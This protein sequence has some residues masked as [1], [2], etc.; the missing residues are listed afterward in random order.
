MTNINTGDPEN[1]YLGHVVPVVEIE[2]D[3]DEAEEI[4]VMAYGLNQETYFEDDEPVGGFYIHTTVKTKKHEYTFSYTFTV[5]QL[6]EI[7]YDQALEAQG[8]STIGLKKAAA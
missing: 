7:L 5:E 6:V 4:A 3:S 8:I 1:K 2:G